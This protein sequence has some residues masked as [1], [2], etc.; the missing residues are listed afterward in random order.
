M[1]KKCWEMAPQ[2]RPTFKELHSSISKYI[3]SIAG[4]LELGFNPFVM[5][6]GSNVGGG[7]EGGEG[8]GGEEE[9][10]GEFQFNVIP[11]SVPADGETIFLNPT[12]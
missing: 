6:D 4:Y 8:D 2:N 9:K 12:T 10:E 7:M 3:E 1:M 11:P 5:K